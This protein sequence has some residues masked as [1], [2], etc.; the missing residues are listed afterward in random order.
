MSIGQFT[1]ASIVDNDFTLDINP[2]VINN[3]VL[4]DGNISYKVTAYTDASNN[5][6]AGI[7]WEV[8]K[9]GSI[10][11]E[12][13]PLSNILSD[14]QVYDIDVCLVKDPFTGD[15]N[16]LTV[17]SVYS[18]SIPSFWAME[19][20]RWDNGANEFTPYLTTPG[21]NVVQTIDLDLRKTAGEIGTSIRIDANDLSEFIIVFDNANQ[22]VFGYTGF[23]YGGTSIYNNGLNFNNIDPFFIDDGVSP[24]VSITRNNDLA[25]LYITYCSYIGSSGSSA[26]KLIVAESGYLGLK[27]I[28]PSPTYTFNIVA[29]PALS[30]VP[31]QFDSPRIASPKIDPF[32]LN[33]YTVVYNVIE[34]SNRF[35][36]YIRGYT[37]DYGAI[38]TYNNGSMG[39]S[40]NITEIVN[41]KPVVTYDNNDQVWVGW[42]INNT[43]GSSAN[44]PPTVIPYPS[45]TDAFFP[46]VV[47]CDAVGRAMLAEYWEVPHVGSNFGS[48]NAIG[49]F[50][51]SGRNSSLELANYYSYFNST[52]NGAGV[53]NLLSKSVDIVSA[54]SLREISKGEHI[55]SGLN[56]FLNDNLNVTNLN[57]II[58]DTQGKLIYSTRGSANDILKYINTDFQELDKSIYLCNLYSADG[59]VNINEK[60]FP[61]K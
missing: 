5:L 46:V 30:P 1:P 27:N 56:E 40:L 22:Q 18:E 36:F 49:T 2:W 33:K 52:P 53:T 13:K 12:V 57:F 24:D 32:N 39:P 3:D 14:Q 45:A 48:N 41:C 28:V 4:D 59:K 19:A 23:V 37:N 8:Y 26:G 54:S 25:D 51:I 31:N 15:V 44:F 10:Y 29:A 16:A 38:Q 55:K 58:I 43:I 61:N 20:F 9:N 35:K 21:G 50:A 42:L 6:V 17:F 34:G 11:K 47:K 60:L 7:M